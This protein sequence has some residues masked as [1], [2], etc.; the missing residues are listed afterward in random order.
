MEGARPG[1]A[2]SPDAPLLPPDP[3]PPESEGYPATDA[4]LALVGGVQLVARGAVLVLRG[5]GPERVLA[6]GLHAP[7]VASTD[8][9]AAVYT[10]S[11]VGDPCPVLD[12]VAA[13][14]GW[15]PRTLVSEGCPD[16]AALDPAGGRV[17]FV[18]DRT[19]IASVYVAPLAGGAPRQLTNVGLEDLP[20]G[21][22]PPPG[23][24]P[25][26]WDGP[27]RFDDGRLVWDGP[28]GPHAV[29]LP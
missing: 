16:R 23:F 15:T 6:L 18:G 7:P 14:D 28:D 21:Q 24:V 2:L 27:L 25:P 22:G 5:A 29:R 3:P 10:H 26:P 13:A 4:D 11:A 12:V 1:L 19:G 20:P 8:G 17:A 9:S